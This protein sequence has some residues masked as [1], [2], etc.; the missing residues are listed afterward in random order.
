MHAHFADT[1]ADTLLLLLLL[2]LWPEPWQPLAQDQ[3]GSAQGGAAAHSS[4]AGTP[5]RDLQVRGVRLCHISRCCIR[6]CQF[7]VTLLTPWV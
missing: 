3:P 1:A 6:V 2:L 5:E 4:T 7:V